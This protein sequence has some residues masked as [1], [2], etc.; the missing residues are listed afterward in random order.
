MLIVERLEEIITETKNITAI[1]RA[2]C[3]EQAK[4]LF[5]ENKHDIVLLDIDL[6]GNKSLK[7]LKEIKKISKETR[8]LILFTR[9]DNYIQEQYNCLGVDFFFDKYY[10]FEK[11]SLVIDCVSFMN[12][13]NTGRTTI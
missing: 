4:K 6:P 2:V 12:S 7:L 8:V 10:E 11:I 5:N 1:H 13:K 9:P 3:Y